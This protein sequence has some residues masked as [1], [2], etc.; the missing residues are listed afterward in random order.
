MTAYGNEA[1]SVFRSRVV[2]ALG[3]GTDDLQENWVI[4][5]FLLVLLVL[6]IRRHGVRLATFVTG[7]LALTL[8]LV[9]WGGTAHPY[10]PL[11]YAP[12]CG[13]AVALAAAA[14]A[15]RG[16][17]TP[18]APDRSPHALVAIP[19]ASLAAFLVFVGGAAQNGVQ[20]WPL[21]NEG[22]G[23]TVR[24]QFGRIMRE[25]A[26]GPVTMLQFGYLDDGFYLAA[27]ALPNTRYFEQTNAFYYWDMGTGQRAWVENKQ[28]QF[29]V[30]QPY[31][32]GW[33][34]S[35]YWGD[36]EFVDVEDVP[37]VSRLPKSWTDNY[38]FVASG[39]GDDKDF[40]LFERND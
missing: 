29:I 32:I 12:F 19:A 22:D 38:H 23:E 17:A 9:N 21:R 7:S 27:G 33:A 6:V 16:A 31:W 37:G 25:N 30:G 34:T 11:A 26:D 8:V 2:Q 40:L 10:Y 5:A 36:A 35:F 39:R 18:D 4:L 13:L 28:G 15:E 24:E 20:D 14:W 3:V 1:N